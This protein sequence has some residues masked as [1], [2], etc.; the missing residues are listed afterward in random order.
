MTLDPIVLD[1]L[2]WEQM[3]TAI[4][5]RIPA[6]SAGTWTLHAPVDPGITVLELYAW[7]LEQR[8]YWLDQVPD[9]FVNAVLRLL[10]MPDR[11]PARAAATVLRFTASKPADAG[12]PAPTMSAGTPF[13]CDPL[14]RVGMTLI[15]DVTV[16]LVAGLSVTADPQTAGPLTVSSTTQD[17]GTVDARPIG[18]LALLP[19]KGK[20][21]EARIT[22]TMPAPI[23]ADADRRL[24]LLAE[25]RVPDPVYPS[26]SPDAVPDVAP[27]A[28]LT[29]QYADGGSVTTFPAADV[30]DGTAGL[31]RSGIIQ[32]RIPDAWRAAPAADAVDHVLIIGAQQCT[33]S[34]PPRLL[35]LCLNAGVAA[36]QR[37]VTGDPTT[38]ADQIRN[39]LP[40]PG[41][42]LDLPDPAAGRLLA[43]SLTLQETDGRTDDWQATT[44]FTMH[45]PDEPVFV[46][47]RDAGALRFGDGRNGR[48]PIPDVSVPPDQLLK[49]ISWVIGGG[50][51]ANG[52]V[53]SWQPTDPAG[54]TTDMSSVTVQNLV[55]VAGG[56]DPESPSQ[57]RMRVV[58]TLTERHRAVTEPDYETVAR[59]TP[60][61]AV[62]RAPALV[63]D[64][65][66]FPCTPVP[67]AVSVYVI[68]DAPREP[69]D[70]ERPDFAARPAPDPGLFKAVSKQLDDGRLIGAE[71]YI[72]PPRYHGVR[73]RATLAGPPV[74]P[75]G[76]RT[77]LT[78]ALCRYLDPITGGDDGS[79][80]PI[81]GPLRP[82]ALLRTAQNAVA[83]SIQIVAVAIWVA[84][85]Q[86]WEACSD[87]AIAANE[88]PVL[89]SL[90]LQVVPATSTPAGG[91]Q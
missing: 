28:N 63:G 50:A 22:I 40:L 33:F 32:I 14:D 10:G 35:R 66:Q 77:Q 12:Q 30:D 67:G 75:A 25:L 23:P 38:L 11:K 80:W 36:E 42:H 6:E 83:R 7:L 74:D 90:D 21:G 81:G 48:I 82:S 15:Q 17:P 59:Q 16:L 34:S 87:V 85:G 2:T 64:H 45:G 88:L 41:Q 61:V 86:R 13:S 18:G 68:P 5:G 55:P 58:A 69:G 76:T 3:T 8:L 51:D 52:G 26:W 49:K 9:T 70:F 43:A 47:D 71:L 1:D 54:T 78:T 91:P 89:D 65:P 72:R 19:A 62:A 73:L 57:A 29:W 84:S 27:P 60:G 39:W 20:Q 56:R 4:R 31:R 46:V 37:E 44:D 79:G 53:T 24:S